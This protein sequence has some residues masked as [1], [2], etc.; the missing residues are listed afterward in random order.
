MLAPKAA[1]AS[2]GG[3]RRDPQIDRLGGS[4]DNADSTA[5]PTIATVGFRLHLGRKFV[6]EVLS[7]GRSGLF[8][9]DWPDIGL[10]PAANLARCKD[11][12]L[13]WAEQQAMTEQRKISV[14]RRLKSLQNFSWSASPARKSELV[15]AEGRT[16]SL[17]AIGGR[18]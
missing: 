17:V 18:Q 9:I 7:D 11:V 14:A 12:A 10:S 15:Q 6:V 16:D 3:Y 8:R 5:F 1:R 2:T 13:A 4:I